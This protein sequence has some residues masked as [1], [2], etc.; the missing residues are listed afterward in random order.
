[1]GA[2]GVG[3][4]GLMVGCGI[5]GGTD[6]TSGGADGKGSGGGGVRGGM[7]CARGGPVGA[8][9]VGGDG[10]MVGSSM[11]GGADGST[12]CSA[13]T[14]PLWIWI[15]PPISTVTRAGWFPAMV[16]THNDT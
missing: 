7:D 16:S 5:D 13:S 14:P 11:D 2:C 15:T 1:M 4:D 10:L 6:A 12:A 3:G 9:G 8:C